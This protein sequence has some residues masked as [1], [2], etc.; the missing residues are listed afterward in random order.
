MAE[1]SGEVSFDKREV[2]SLVFRLIAVLIAV[3]VGVALL[4]YF[5]RPTAEGIARGFV[6][7]FGVWGMALGTFVADGLHFPVPPQFYMLL[8]VASGT[9]VWRAF[10]A[11]AAASVLAGYAGYSLA[12]Q[13]VRLPWF[14]RKTEHARYLLSKAFDRYGYRAALIASLLPIPYSLLCYL[15]GL[16]RLPAR[17]WGILA[18]C[19]VPKLCAF[20]YLVHLGWSFA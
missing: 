19:R 17:F 10:A 7:R 20:Y 2:L 18:A 3:S 8:A 9:P 13:A 12:G 4:G 16:N 11:I 6:Q 5:L 14:A 1:G 15:A